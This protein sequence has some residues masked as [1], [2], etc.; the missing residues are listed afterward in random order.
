MCPGDH[1][2]AFRRVRPA[3]RLN[4]SASGQHGGK[5]RVPA[6]FI[7]DEG[8]PLR[9]S[10]SADDPLAARPATS[11]R[12]RHGSAGP[13]TNGRPPT[14]RSA[15]R[16]PDE[17]R[18]AARGAGRPPLSC[19]R[20]RAV[21]LRPGQASSASP[22]GRPSPPCRGRR[23]AGTARNRPG[24]GRVVRIGVDEVDPATAETRRGCTPQRVACRTSASTSFAARGRVGAC[25]TPDSS[26]T[27]C[28]SANPTGSAAG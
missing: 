12:G 18:L 24:A 11:F 25:A 23:R 20:R 4:L 17:R 10:S 19:E 16:S 8:V 9:S 27:R 7:P 26:A 1:A 6:P 15:G 13:G 5:S 14:R 3:W 21:Q 28:P 2:V 22:R